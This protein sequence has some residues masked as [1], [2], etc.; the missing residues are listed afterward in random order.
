MSIVYALI[1]IAVLIL[2]HE[3][4]HFIAARR[5]GIPVHEFSL[6]FGYR[7]LGTKRGDT[8][9]SIRLI[10]L[11]GYVRMAGEEPGDME[12]P[13]GYNART[14]LEKMRVSFAGPF[15]NFILAILIFI[16][17]NAVIGIA[18]PTKDAI[19]DDVL[20][21]KPAYQAGLKAGD[22]I[23]A[24]NHQEVSSWNQF[25]E[26]VRKQPTGK[27]MQLTVR[28]GQET[29]VLEMIPMKDKSTGNTIIGVS[30]KYVFER[31]GILAAIKLGFV[32]T[33]QMTVFM[34]SSLG[35]MFTGGV[36]ANDL[37]GP[38]G[39]TSLIGDAAR[40]GLVSLL[41]FSAFLSINLGILNLLPIPALDG[42]RIMFAIVEVIRRKPMNPEKEG[43]IHFIGF[44]FLM[45]IILFATYNDIIRLIKG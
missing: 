44:V 14:P 33:Y 22:Q 38:V 4:G 26:N 30:G 34:L 45:L 41:T 9:Y 17:T 19:I 42:S 23:L 32:Q 2:F 15:M 11:G 40:N 21:D 20:K 12:N 39:I 6:G 37:A 35:M 29:K 27:P 43:Y 1:I 24:V 25:V 7:L 16:I 31:K 13:D 36:S 18:V 28:R 3:L 5:I 8:E 10:P